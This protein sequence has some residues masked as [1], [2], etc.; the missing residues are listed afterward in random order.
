M[1]RVETP[2]GLRLLDVGEGYVPGVIRDELEVER[3]RLHRLEKE[4]PVT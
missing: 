4:P 2:P 1:A 3:V